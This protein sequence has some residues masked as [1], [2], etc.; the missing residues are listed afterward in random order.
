MTDAIAIDFG[1][2]RTKAAYW[3]KNTGKPQLMHL[4]YHNEPFVASLFY[5]SAENGDVLWGQKAEAKIEDDPK[6]IIDVLKRRLQE[7]YVYANHRKETPQILLTEMLSGLRQRAGAEVAAFDGRTPAKVLLTVPALYGPAFAKLV[8]DAAR[9]AGFAEIELVP[10]PVAAARAWLAETGED[11]REVVVLDCGGG[12]LDWAF[13]SY[14]NGNFRI[15]P[16]CPSGCD[17]RVGGYDVDMELLNELG[18]QVEDRAEIE[19]RQPYYLREIRNLKER[20]CRNL[21]LQPIKLGDR[22]VALDGP[23]IQSVL[24]SR[25]VHQAVESLRSYLSKIEQVR[26]GAE[27]TVLLVGGSAR[28]KGL[29]EAIEKQTGRPT[30]W[31]ERSEFATVLGGVLCYMREEVG[32]VIACISCGT[33]MYIVDA[34]NSTATCPQC[35]NRLEI[36]DG[37][38]LLAQEDP[39]EQFQRAMAYYTGVGAPMDDHQAI[40]WFRKAADRGHADAQEC[41]GDTYANGEGVPQDDY[42]AV[43]W[44][45]KAAEQGN[46][47]GQFSLGIMYRDGRGVSQNDQ[48][49]VAWFHKAAEQGHTLS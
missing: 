44:Y 18:E 27:P 31:W 20:Y 47:Y 4:G 41:L 32:T 16:E 15:I 19:R 39:E 7:R 1:T 11:G 37:V 17:T 12:T 21:D 23:T 38:V 46:M 9:E 43:A 29:K 3:D 30:V 34:K 24:D 10:E 48:Q 25:F 6:G 8:Q 5:L 40:A 36:N 14:D 35:G 13:M 2:S 22:Q 42:Q 45:L 33:N 49:A 26:P 28:I